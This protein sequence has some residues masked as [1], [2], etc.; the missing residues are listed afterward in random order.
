[1]GAVPEVRGATDVRSTPARARWVG[2]L[3]DRRLRSVVAFGPVV[4]TVTMDVV[5]GVPLLV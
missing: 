4:A 2:A 3:T 1:V 5:F